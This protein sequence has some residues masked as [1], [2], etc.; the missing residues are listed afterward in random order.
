MAN[1]SALKKIGARGVLGDVTGT[2]VPSGCIG[3]LVTTGAS[4]VTLTTGTYVHVKELTLPSGIWLMTFRGDITGANASAY[5]D[6]GISTIPGN[7]T[8]GMVVGSTRYEL[9]GVTP[10]SGTQFAITF[11][12]VYINISNS[13]TYY[14]KI[15][16]SSGTANSA[17]CIFE[18]VRIA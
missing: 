17:R 13:T 8:S 7:G 18:A 10:A 5:Y 15:Y 9:V 2:T 1:L 16:Q 3:Q 11:P 4:T 12:N 6:A 14:A